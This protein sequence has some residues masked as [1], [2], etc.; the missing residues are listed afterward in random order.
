MDKSTDKKETK[1]WSDWLERI[2]SKAKYKIV[3][4]QKDLSVNGVKLEDAKEE[5]RPCI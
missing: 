5:K 3:K 4:S 1:S 2:K